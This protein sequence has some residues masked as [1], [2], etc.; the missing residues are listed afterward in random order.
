MRI[1]SESNSCYVSRAVLTVVLFVKAQ[2]IT[3]PDIKYLV[4]PSR[5]VGLQNRNEVSRN[6]CTPEE[7]LEVDFSLFDEPLMLAGSHEIRAEG[8]KK[9]SRAD[10]LLDFESEIPLQAWDDEL[11]N[12]IG[13]QLD[14]LVLKLLQIVDDPRRDRRIVV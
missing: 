12:D 10:V 3:V 7:Y 5:K 4:S 13:T 8:V 1:V 14:V 2:M 9:R 11:G 6:R